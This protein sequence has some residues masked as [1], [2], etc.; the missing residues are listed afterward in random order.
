M[1][2]SKKSSR[3]VVFR[4]RRFTKKTVAKSVKRYVKQ[5]IHRQAENKL[6]LQF[7]A[8]VN[9][10]CAN[11]TT[12]TNLNLVPTPVGGNNTVHRIGNSIKVVRGYVRGHINMLGYN[13]ISNP[14]VGPIYVKMWIVSSK[15]INTTSLS[16][17]NIAND[18]FETGSTASGFQANM[19]DMNLSVNSDA[20]TVHKTKVLTLGSTTANGGAI[21]PLANSVASNDKFS[22]PFYFNIAPYMK[23]VIKFSDGA[24]SPTNINLFLILQAVNA[25]GSST[26]ITPAE[27]HYSLRV[28]YEDI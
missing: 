23:K 11:A 26:A 22:R 18:F 7:A 14:N 25:D 21:N 20:Y 12:P 4:K 28:E 3:K 15:V 8:N 17:T 19:L 27:Y 1:K 16:S 24:T 10:N 9:I 5:A 13:S 2:Y 6:S